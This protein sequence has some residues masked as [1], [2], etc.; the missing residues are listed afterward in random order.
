MRVPDLL[1]SERSSCCERM[2]S[3]GRRFRNVSQDG[4]RAGVG[5]SASVMEARMLIRD[6]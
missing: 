1:D 2:S 6:P 3:L 5:I 4:N